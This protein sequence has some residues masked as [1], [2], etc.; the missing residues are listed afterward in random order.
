MEQ[1]EQDGYGGAERR[2]V[3]PW[4]VKIEQDIGTIHEQLARNTAVTEANAATMTQVRELLEAP[5]T[6]W[7]WCSKWGRR[8]SLF[9]K[10]A[11]PIV[12][13]GVAVNQFLHVDLWDLALKVLRR[14]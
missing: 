10:W 5:A 11:A 9:A 12:G 1:F 3:D 4:R 14:S 7:A 13:L 8:I 6:F 2:K